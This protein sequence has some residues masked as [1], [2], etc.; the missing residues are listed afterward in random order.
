MWRY[1]YKLMAWEYTG[2]KEQAEIESARWWKYKAIQEIK[3]QTPKLKPVSFSD[4]VR[5]K[6]EP[7]SGLVPM[8]VNESQCKPQSH[9]TNEQTQIEISRWRKYQM[10]Q[11]IKTNPK[12]LKPLERPTSFQK[13]H[14]SP[15]SSDLQPVLLS[16]FLG[17]PA[18]DVSKGSSLTS[19]SLRAHPKIMRWSQKKT[20]ARRMS[21]H[22]FNL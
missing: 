11:E 3:T 6:S 9:S 16:G 2:R 19:L 12:K 7:S 5:P 8:D 15:C 21:L 13:A 17:E 1:I 10:T 22:S 20:A 4:S 14:P 18:A